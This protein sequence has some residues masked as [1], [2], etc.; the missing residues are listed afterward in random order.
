MTFY[1]LKQFL[2]KK[3]RLSHV[4]QPLLIKTLIDSGGSA[5]VRQPAVT[6]LTVVKSTNYPCFLSANIGSQPIS[7]PPA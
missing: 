6:S 5:T 3:M 4:Y 1:E 7:L 2:L